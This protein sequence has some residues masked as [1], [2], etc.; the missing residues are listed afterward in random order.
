MLEMLF[1][2]TNLC[3][4]MGC[5][6]NDWSNANLDRDGED[7]SPKK[8]YSQKEQAATDANGNIIVLS[9]REK[10]R[11]RTLCPCCFA[12]CVCARVCACVCACAC[13]CVHVHLCV[14][15]EAQN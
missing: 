10:D 11:R 1:Q 8:E 2:L 12:V 5:R 4:I 6:N 15:A 14:C 7:N 9:R 13:V 3:E